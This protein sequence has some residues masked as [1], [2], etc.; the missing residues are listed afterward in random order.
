MAK[1]EGRELHP[2]FTARCKSDFTRNKGLYLLFVPVLVY[3]IIFQ[4]CPMFGLTIAFKNY[5]PSRGFLD[6]PWVGLKHFVAFFNDYYFARV[7]F[8][9]IRISVAT[10]VFGFPMPIILA[11]LINELKTKR[12]SRIVQTISY[13]PHFIS[14]VVV[15]GIMVQ[16]TA[17]EGAV[18]QFLA[19]FGF[20]PVTMLNEPKLFTPLYVFSYNWQTIGWNSIIY[21]S[22]LM[23]IDREMYEA[24]MIDGAGR[25][26]QILSI[27]LPCLLP[28][29]VIMLI[30]QI[31][32]MF[33][34]GYE[35]I[36]LMYNP[37]TYEKADV[38]STYVYRKGL[39]EFNWSYSA[40]VGMFNSV[41]SF[42]LVFLSNKI[43]R[44]VSG[45]SLW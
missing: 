6:S 4:Y 11:L 40:A 24:A 2:G 12:Y 29:I 9:T 7:F 35:K 37:L 16:L 14:V 15:I 1:S 34:V 21:L 10:L 23:A 41:V 43:S 3:Y 28:T 26:R 25:F 36:L 38:I 45:N 17:R 44:H 30:L 18:T 22:A 8:N 31:G 32:K 39:L 33:N 42:T 20:E 13:I 5:T 19:L 27:T